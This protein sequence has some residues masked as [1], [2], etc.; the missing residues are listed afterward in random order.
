M[1]HGTTSAKPEV[2]LPHCEP[3]DV[4]REFG[5]VL[6][7][8]DV[9]Q[10]HIMDQ[11]T[12]IAPLKDLYELLADGVKG[13]EEAASQVKTPELKAFLSKLAAERTLLKLEMAQAIQ[14]IK[15]NA[16]K[17]D[18]GTLKGSLHRAWIDIRESLSSSTDPAVLD[19]CDRGEKYLLNRYREVVE[20]KK[21][22]TAVHALLREQ[23]ATIGVTRAMIKD[24]NNTLEY[25]D[26]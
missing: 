25:T 15:P 7:R 5:M 22:P 12:S 20:D 13:Y 2:L 4:L 24:L 8:E 26:A 1:K 19:E 17:P 11:D 9:K 10:K 6:A 23:L 14:H 16:G 3:V 21:T 18:E